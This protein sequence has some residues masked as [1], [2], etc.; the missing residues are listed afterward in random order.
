MTRNLIVFLVF[1]FTSVSFSQEL[2]ATVA[3][4]YEQVNN[5]NPQLFKNLEKQVTEFLNN[6]KWAEKVVNEIEKID[7]NF[8][9]IR[10]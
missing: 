1:L 6:T 10:L 8:L 5:G 2:R 9:N 7:C 4:N 3:I